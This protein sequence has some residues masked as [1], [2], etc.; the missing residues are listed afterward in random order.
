MQVG[1]IITLKTI[2]FLGVAAV[3]LGFGSA[4][5]AQTFYTDTD[6]YYYT[7]GSDSNGNFIQYYANSNVSGYET[8][9]FTISSSTFTTTYGYNS[10]TM[11]V[12][13]SFASFNA[14]EFGTLTRVSAGLLTDATVNAEVTNTN[15]PTD[16]S[17]VNYSDLATTGFIKISSSATGTSVTQTAGLA[18][19]TD[20][21]N[22]GS[23]DSGTYGTVT[24][25]SDGSGYAGTVSGGNS[26]YIYEDGSGN[27]V[28]SD[29]STDGTT[30]TGVA[31]STTTTN[32]T[33]LAKYA[34]TVGQSVA[35]TMAQPTNSVTLGAVHN[36]GVN[37]GGNIFSTTTP[38]VK[39]YFTSSS[40]PE[41]GSL[42]FA[43]LG[44]G[45][46]ALGWNR[47]RRIDA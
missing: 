31:A 17:D 23:S 27:T 24:N 20:D 6:G 25:A 43:L 2:S 26:Y 7:I 42:A 11:K 15:D 33:T 4:A 35:F 3:A 13:L 21:S 18:L 28:Y 12:T 44:F 16:L 37:L 29:T 34:T 41:P 47:K 10:G 38:S 8:T 1:R 5:R 19:P 9:P 22:L 46:A 36:N 30:F 14:S 39:Y 32:G 40:L 45:G